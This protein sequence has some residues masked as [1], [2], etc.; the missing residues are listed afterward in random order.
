MKK[1]YLPIL[2]T[3]ALSACSSPGVKNYQKDDV[4]STANETSQPDWADETK[5]FAIR[6][7]KV[8]SVG[9]AWIRGDEIP[10]AGTRVAANNARSNI[11]KAVENRMEFVF[12]QG[13]ENFS[14]DSQTAKFI[15]S[16]VSRTTSSS[17][18]E[19][20]TWWAR[21]AQSQED[22]SRTIRYKIFSLITMPE[23]DFKVAVQRAMSG[24][25]QERKI[26]SE[27][28]DQLSKQWGR[29]VEGGEADAK[30]PE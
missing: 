10:S 17:M 16:E 4:L 2:A 6:D 26:S 5:P 1:I 7:G 3:L 30:K 13:S 23:A 28:K 25:N 19:E 22:G 9:V 8:L 24:S 18:R 11:A 27:F 15:G 12:Q 14:M 20:A 29:F 21:V